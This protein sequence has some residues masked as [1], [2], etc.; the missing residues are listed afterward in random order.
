M[1]T[2]KL[3]SREQLLDE[4]ITLH[5]RIEFLTQSLRDADLLAEAYRARIPDASEAEEP[6]AS[7]P[8][9]LAEIS[10][11]HLEV[12]ILKHKLGDRY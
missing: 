3:Q 2:D 4:I 6:Q 1:P 7:N 12:S 9:D 10:R 5:E 8:D 11:L